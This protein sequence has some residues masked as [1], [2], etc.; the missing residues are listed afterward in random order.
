MAGDP[1][2]SDRQP[3]PFDESAEKSVFLEK[4]AIFSTRYP[5]SETIFEKETGSRVNENT[6]K[7]RASKTVK[8]VVWLAAAGLLAC[9]RYDA[10]VEKALRYAGDNRAELE[11]VLE[12]YGAER[13][14]SQK[15]RAASFLIANMPYHRSYP[16]EAYAAYCAQMDSLFRNGSKGDTLLV[17]RATEISDR[18][19]PH[20]NLVYD[21]RTITADYL[22]WNI[23]YSFRLWKTSPFLEH[24]DFD[25]FCE[26]V[27]PYKCFEGQPMTRWKESWSHIL[28]GELDLI[29]QIDEL[30][31]NVRRAVEAVTYTY[32]QS[33]SLRMEVRQIDGMNHIDL[34][35]LNALAV[36]PYGTCLE[37]SRLGVMDCRS[38]GLPVSFDFTP[39]WADR[40]G[41]H[42]WNHVLVSRRRSPDFEPFRIYPG[43]YHYPD[44]AMAKVYR[45]TY[46]PHPL[47]MEVVEKGLS[48]PASLS[49]LFM[50]D[51]TQEY[52]R[53]ADLTI[54]LP[55]E[56]AQTSGYAYLA[57]FDN[58]DWVP[59]DICRIAH[60]KAAF[61]NVGIDI[62]YL[63]VACEKGQIIPLSD[64]FIVDLHRRVN[65]LRADAHRTQTLHLERKFPAF[66]H[67][68][69]R[70][71]NLRGGVIEAAD[72]RH[73]TD[74][75]V[76]AVLPRDRFLSGEVRVTDTLP[77]RYWRLRSTEDEASDFAELYFY[78]R[79][80]LKRIA[81][82][83]FAPPAPVRNKKYDTA[84]HLCDN[85]PLTYFAIESGDCP[86]WAGFDF[87]RPVAMGRV[88]F[89][90]RGDGNDICPGDEYE[91]YYWDA[92]GWKLHAQQR[93]ERVSLDFEG[94]PVGGLYFIKGL[95]RGVQNRTFICE[96]HEI[97]WY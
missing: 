83:I 68:Y 73:F 18:F 33:D 35:D 70:R 1:Y 86:R 21:V 66:Q 64:P 45:L 32:R 82:T 36:Q 47:L 61:R 94:V 27:L 81:G 96:D 28:R 54:P 84:E 62:L 7:M 8:A 91:L 22:I 2:A 10:G 57:V 30:R 51:V 88:A 89:I 34:F 71:K 52:G 14:D 48:L 9:T 56:S 74:P 20:L 31:R 29:G 59:V 40:G 37:R 16:A 75:V 77:H 97:R 85:D 55:S 17:K 50:R 41:P 4:R 46:A 11:R 6:G 38:K 87:H 13:A 43:A 3:R 44:N 42:Y 5:D 19:A 80:S 78:D 12:H 72:D 60:E 49:Q 15:F 25:D 63:V 65:Y 23:D 39:N 92:G 69:D 93:A 90:R 24:L 95:S 67:I 26:Y 76:A 53:T 79:D 58:A